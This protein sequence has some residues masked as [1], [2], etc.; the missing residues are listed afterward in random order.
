VRYARRLAIGPEGLIT[1]PIR[2]VTIAI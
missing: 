1:M 2:V